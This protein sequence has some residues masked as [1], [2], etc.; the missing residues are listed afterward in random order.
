MA[1]KKSSPTKKKIK[2]AKQKPVGSE[3]QQDL[4]SDTPA[5]NTEPDDADIYHEP[6]SVNTFT[7]GSIELMPWAIAMDCV[8]VR[9]RK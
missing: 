2:D 9:S 7:I 8:F 4:P 1:P 6:V 5:Q 3:V